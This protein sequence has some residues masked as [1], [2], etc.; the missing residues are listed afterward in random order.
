[1][2]PLSRR[3]PWQIARETATLDHLSN[4]RLILF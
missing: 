1:M 3:Q 2:T 4:G